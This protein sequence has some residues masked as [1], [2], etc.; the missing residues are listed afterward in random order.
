VHFA[1]AELAAVNAVRV[2]HHN[3]QGLDFHKNSFFLFQI[4]LPRQ[5]R[6]IRV[7]RNSNAGDFLHGV[8][9]SRAGQKRVND[10][11]IFI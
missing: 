2:G 5:T 6:L 7:W 1:D 9:T 4:A 11:E 3:G 8:C 10:T